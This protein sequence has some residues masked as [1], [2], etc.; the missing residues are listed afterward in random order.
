MAG[1]A[2]CACRALVPHDRV[3]DLRS[4]R[5]AWEEPALL[6]RVGAW[7]VRCSRCGRRWCGESLGG[8]G[9]YGDTLWWDA[10]T[11]GPPGSAGA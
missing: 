2:T 8:G 5:G 10:P 9:I 3:Y 6:E 1:D 11:E 4:V 7:E